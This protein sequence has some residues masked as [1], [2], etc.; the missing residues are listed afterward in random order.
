MFP[1]FPLD[2]LSPSP[3]SEALPPFLVPKQ[4]AKPIYR[5]HSRFTAQEDVRLYRLVQEHGAKSWRLIAKYMPNR[6]SRQ[7]RERWL[8]YLNPSLNS[9]SWTATEDALLEEK[10]HQIGPRWVFMMKFFPNR[11]DAMLK[12]RF[13]VLRRKAMRQALADSQDISSPG[14]S[15][16]FELEF[17]LAVHEKFSITDLPSPFDEFAF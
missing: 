5:P 4:R 7:C 11:T 10:Y 16:G 3:D 1:L 8:N 6:N 9:E 13:Q 15:D 14:N 2:P 12:N 17:N